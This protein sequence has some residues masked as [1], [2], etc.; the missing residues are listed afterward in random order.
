MSALWEY[1]RRVYLI[2]KKY[3]IA[4]TDADAFSAAAAAQRTHELVQPRADQIGTALKQI[5]K[6]SEIRETERDT[7]KFLKRESFFWHKL[8]EWYNGTVHPN[9]PWPEPAVLHVW[10]Q[11]GPA[12]KKSKYFYFSLDTINAIWEKVRLK[13]IAPGEDKEEYMDNWMTFND[14]TPKGKKMERMWANEKQTIMAEIR[15]VLTKQQWDKCF[16]VTREDRRIVAVPFP[17]WTRHYLEQNRINTIASL[18]G[19]LKINN[20]PTKESDIVFYQSGFD[21]AAAENVIKLVEREH[22]AVQSTQRREEFIASVAA[23][24]GEDVAASLEK[25]MKTVPKALQL[26]TY[27]IDICFLTKYV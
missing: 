15:K 5:G 4:A 21:K 6:E 13:G 19:D 16:Q 17:A 22:A 24:A 8:N 23:D 26:Q 1:S 14:L 18:N 3:S 2:S 11:F 25:S 27:K 20:E 7:W 9:A 10:T 12:V